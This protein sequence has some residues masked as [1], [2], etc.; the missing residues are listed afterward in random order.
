MCDPIRVLQVF[1][2]D[3]DFVLVLCIRKMVPPVL[4]FVRDGYTP[5]LILV[6]FAVAIA[7]VV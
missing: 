5:T 2:C 1:A 4:D 7:G 3:P 6:L